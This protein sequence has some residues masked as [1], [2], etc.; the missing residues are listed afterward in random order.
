MCKLFGMYSVFN[1][2]NLLL[3]GA[4]NV[5]DSLGSNI[6]QYRLMKQEINY[7]YLGK[8]L[9]KNSCDECLVDK[10]LFLN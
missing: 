1:M 6:V 5:S 4:V 9:S 2:H 8:K 7:F 10:R 3:V